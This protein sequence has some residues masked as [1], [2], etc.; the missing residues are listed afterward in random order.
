MPWHEICD[1]SFSIC[2][3]LTTCSS[4]AW[5]PQDVEQILVADAVVNF[6]IVPIET[7]PEQI[8]VL[9]GYLLAILQIPGLRFQVHLS[10]KIAELS[11][12][13]QAVI[14]LISMVKRVLDPFHDIFTALLAFF[15]QLGKSLLKNSLSVPLVLRVGLLEV[16][17]VLSQWREQLV[18][19]LDLL[20]WK[21]VRWALWSARV[22]G[23]VLDGLSLL[24][25]E[26][27]CLG[28]GGWPFDHL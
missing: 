21:P 1:P 9:L 14:W 10:H 16:L 15:V 25:V 22:E 19:P 2:R 13:E 11:L 20:S 23:Q 3:S 24:P 8:N 27:E 5:L 26:A 6:P 12:L 18:L 4:H 7:R 28:Y 17:S